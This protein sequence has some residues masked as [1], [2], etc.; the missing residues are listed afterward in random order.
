VGFDRSVYECPRCRVSFAPLDKE[1]GLGAHETMTR[2]FVKRVAWEVAQVS[3]PKAV[4]NLAHQA[5]LEVS[6]AECARVAGQYGRR[7]DAIQR[8]REGQ[9]RMPWTPEASPA[10]PERVGEGMVFQ[11][12]AT[13]VLTVRGEDDKQVYCATAFALEGRLK[14]EGDAG[15]AMILERRY[16]ASGVD[17]EDFEGRFKA[18]TRR[19]G[20]AHAGRV[21]F[22]GDGAPCLWNL[23]RE[24][25]PGAVFIQDYWHVCER[26]GGVAKEIFGEGE[27]ARDMARKWTEVLRGSRLEEI[28]E[29]LAKEKKRRRG[30]KRK[31]IESEIHYLE[32]GR[33][34]M[35]YARFEREGWPIGSGAVE[36]TCKHLV[37]E[38]YC[39]T[40]A[41]WKRENIPNVL[42]LRLSLFN[43]EWEEDWRNPE[44]A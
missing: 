11:A 19:M 32:S 10:A 38:R 44:A 34:R 40:G 26:L 41:R 20:A 39:V 37:R 28:L 24:V 23:A 9:W 29:D 36:G 15:R 25:V 8:E 2:R 35:D 33:A 27:Q 16:S 22:L 43:E 1:L 18:L 30:R 21:A 3:F 5:G 7:F 14:K 12:D 4:K 31:R 17:F 13:S 42:A 6:A